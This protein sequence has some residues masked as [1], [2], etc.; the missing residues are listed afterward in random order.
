MEDL[1]MSLSQPTEVYSDSKSAIYIV[2]NSVQHD[3][4]KHVRIDKSFIKREIEGGINLSYIPITN[5]VAD[6]FTK[7]VAS[8]GFELP[9]GKL[10]M[11]CIYSLA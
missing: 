6:I 4:M 5:Q 9:I 1:G 11:T 8:P 2:K 10:G 7:T 3:R